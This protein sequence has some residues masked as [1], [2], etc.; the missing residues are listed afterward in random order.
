MNKTNNSIKFFSYIFSISLLYFIIVVAI[1]VVCFLDKNMLLKLFDKFS[2]ENFLPFKLSR[3]DLVIIQDDLMKYLSGKIPFLETKVTINNVISDFY[4]IR[5]KVH[6]GDVRNIFMIIFKLSYASIIICIITFFQ[7]MRKEENPFSIIG[8]SFTRVVIIF[9]AILLALF[10]YAAIDF[11][12]FFVSFHETLFTNDYWLLDPNE[13]YIICLLPEK[14]F[15][16][17]GLRL[18]LATI[19]MITMFI[20][21]FRLLSKIQLR[22]EA[23]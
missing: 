22:Q 10:I 12:S 7:I 13:D 5:S 21:G 6:M 17:I 19:I 3:E 14:L 15:M 18:V 4:G 8:K 2:V 20:F 9:T 23:K 16:L 1:Y 11:D